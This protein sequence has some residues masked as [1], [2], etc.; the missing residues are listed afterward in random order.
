MARMFANT[1]TATATNNDKQQQQTTATT[2]SCGRGGNH[3]R[4]ST[5]DSVAVASRVFAV[6][7]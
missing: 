5:R 1:A 3:L 4:A 7:R 6:I 2:I